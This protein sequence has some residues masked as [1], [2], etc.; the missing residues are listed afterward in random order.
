MADTYGKP[1]KTGNGQK[2]PTPA[3]PIPQRKRMA[4]AGERDAKDSKVKW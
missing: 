3:Q 1:S 4:M 2:P